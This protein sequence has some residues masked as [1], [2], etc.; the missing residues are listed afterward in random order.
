[1]DQVCASFSKVCSP[2]TTVR[3]TLEP[4]TMFKISNIN[5]Y[6]DW[7]KRNKYETNISESIQIFA[8][9]IDLMLPCCANVRIISVKCQ[10]RNFFVLIYGGVKQIFTWSYFKIVIFVLLYQ[11]TCSKLTPKIIFNNLNK[12]LLQGLRACSLHLFPQL[13]SDPIWEL[14]IKI[15]L[16]PEA[17]K[18]QSAELERERK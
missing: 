3:C 9:W 6:I 5:Q 4:S 7:R 13:W 2:H 8:V 18:S 17:S 10:N 15:L 12:A 11:S 16:Q 1:M 14:S